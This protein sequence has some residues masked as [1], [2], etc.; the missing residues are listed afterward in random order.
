[1]S[2][3]IKETVLHVLWP[4]SKLGDNYT[5]NCHLGG[6]YLVLWSEMFFYVDMSAEPKNT[7]C[8]CKTNDLPPQK[9]VVS[10]LMHL[11]GILIL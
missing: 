3:V 4:V 5:Q 10:I 7:I 8:D 6:K 1:M 9:T 2:H 11:Y